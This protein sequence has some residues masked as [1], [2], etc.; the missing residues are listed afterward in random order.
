MSSMLLWINALIPG[1]IAL[2]DLDCSL[3]GACI[4]EPTGL[5]WMYLSFSMRFL[6]LKTLKS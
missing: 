4:V 2:F 1:S 5:R 3:G 6:S